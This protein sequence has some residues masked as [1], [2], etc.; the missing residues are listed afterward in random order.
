MLHLYGTTPGTSPGQKCGYVD[1][2]GKHG[3]EPITGVC[4]WS[5]QRGPG[6]EPLVKESRGAV[7]G[8]GV[9]GGAKPPEAEN[10]S[11]FGCPMEATNLPHSPYFANS[12]NPRYL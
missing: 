7:L 6:A 12:L 2:H 11:A 3:D 5:P 10:L 4:G 9:T 1:T 8:Q